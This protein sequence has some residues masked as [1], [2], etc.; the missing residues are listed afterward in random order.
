M[1]SQADLTSL[2]RDI[3][4]KRQLIIGGLARP[5]FALI[6][7]FSVAMRTARREDFSEG[8]W[9]FCE[10]RKSCLSLGISVRIALHRLDHLN[11]KR[12][13]ACCF[14]PVGQENSFSACAVPTF[15][16]AEDE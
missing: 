12:V 8:P 1:W 9:A 11:F 13:P 7:N 2:L 6:S 10:I 3:D 5:V 15:V 4:A 16:V 14:G